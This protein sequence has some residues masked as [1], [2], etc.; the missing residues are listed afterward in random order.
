MISLTGRRAVWY[1]RISRVAHAL[2]PPMFGLALAGGIYLATRQAGTIVLR[3]RRG[4]PGG[5]LTAP[6]LL[7]LVGVT[8]VAASLL[9]F[10]RKGRMLRQ[11]LVA[12][13]TAILFFGVGYRR[14]LASSRSGSFFGLGTLPPGQTFVEDFPARP[15][16]EYKLNSWGLRGPDF[17]ERKPEGA[18]RVA[19]VGDSFVF[20]SGV[21]ERDSLPVRLA[22]LLRAR[23]PGAPIEVQNLGIP[24]DNLASHLAVSRV[25]DQRLGADVVVLCLTLPNDLS[26]WDGQAERR[27]H[28]R[29]GGFSFVSLMFGRATAITLWDERNLARDV[30]DAGVALL[31]SEVDRL[32]AERA[33]GAPRPLVIFAY[34][35][36]EP[37][38]TA[39]LRSVPGAVI[40]PPVSFDEAHYLPGDGHPTAAGNEVFARRIAGVFEGGWLGAR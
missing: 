23:F 5:E 9:F 27:E 31:R 4:A 15:R 29:V 13:A 39:I 38:V 35:F 19:V 28:A 2:E 12:A 33:A 17:T 40:V 16:V 7:L 14:E 24:G 11:R 37:R 3:D 18:R 10:H 34:S 8:I 25:A 26:A 22:S 21:E 36:E 1:A 32:A 6:G 30:T 20:G